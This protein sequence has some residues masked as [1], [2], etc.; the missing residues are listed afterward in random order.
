MQ[1][2]YLVYK[3]LLISSVISFLKNLPV[4][5]ESLRADFTQ[6]EDVMKKEFISQELLSLVGCLDT[7]EEGGRYILLN[8][9]CIFK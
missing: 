6:V 1:L 7:S 8:L 2:K 3:L 9:S 4:L 5:K